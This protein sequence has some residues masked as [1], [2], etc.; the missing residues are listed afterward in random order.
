VR[1][2]CKYKKCLKI[3]K[4]LYLVFYALLEAQYIGEAT[5]DQALIEKRF[6]LDRAGLKRI[7]RGY[8]GGIELELAFFGE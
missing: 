1:L 8:S 4:L 6:M 5:L 3:N 2:L 7:Y